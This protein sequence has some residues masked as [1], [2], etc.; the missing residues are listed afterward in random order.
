MFSPIKNNNNIGNADYSTVFQKARASEV[1]KLI[2]NGLDKK[3]L[4]EVAVDAIKTSIDN[5]AYSK[6]SNDEAKMLKFVAKFEEIFPGEKSIVQDIHDYTTAKL[7]VVNDNP[8]AEKQG[9]GK[10]GIKET[11]QKP[12]RPQK[13]YKAA[14]IPE[15]TVQTSNNTA[16]LSAMHKVLEEGYLEYSLGDFTTLDQADT[17]FAYVNTHKTEMQKKPEIATRAH[18]ILH[19]IAQFQISQKNFI[20][21]FEIE[22]KAAEVIPLSSTHPLYDIDK[23]IVEGA[24]KQVSPQR[25]AHFSGLDTTIVKGGNLH[26]TQRVI[27]GALLNTVD[28]KMSHYARDELNDYLNAVY[29]NTDDFKASLP[30]GLCTDVKINYGQ[31]HQYVRFDEATG[32]FT[33]EGAYSPRSSKA[34]EI[35]FEG[36]GKVIIGQ[37]QE[38]GCMYNWIQVEMDA[39][40]PPEE[41]LKKLHQMLAVTGLGPVLGTQPKEADER[42][43][44]VQ[45]LRAFYPAMATRY[46]TT[47][48]FY[49]LSPDQLR[50]K[51]IKDIEPGMDAVFKKYLDDQPFLMEKIEIMP[52]KEIWGIKDLGQ[53]MKANGAYGLMTGIGSGGWEAAKRSIER[54]LTE[55]FMSTEQRYQSGL[56]KAGAS[57]EADLLRGG[58]DQIFTRLINKN[59]IEHGIYSFPF[60]GFAQIL[61]DLNRVAARVPYG[62][63]EDNF[64]A[65]NRFGNQYDY[66]LYKDRSNLMD[67]ASSITESGNEIMTKNSMDPSYVVGVVVKDVYQKDEL[68]EHLLSKGLA[69]ED[70][71]GDIYIKINDNKIKAQD[72]IRIAS[73]GTFEEEWWG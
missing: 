28:F 12:Q 27:D 62:F 56:F 1:N 25:G 22:A 45:L 42:M 58:G 26:A 51:I 18:Q 43:K 70:A 33:R 59:T 14:Q 9:V 17:V 5:F 3:V 44:I 4:L 63:Q 49:Q 16:P 57:S 8:A 31:S 60:H 36:A 20:E 55:G 19:N 6:D 64:G 35:E 32:E 71:I 41:G 13:P 65:R 61:W 21:A 29:T 46:D 50:E 30:P 15:K 69:E 2:N 11:V 40:L 7:G 52:G 39:N 67:L 73:Q 37:D 53:Q 23:A 48:E 66:D 72:F 47:K 24:A 68:I 10:Q 34:T 54:T 38:S